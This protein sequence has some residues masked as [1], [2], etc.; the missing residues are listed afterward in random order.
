MNKKCALLPMIPALLGGVTMAVTVFLPYLANSY[1]SYS[2]IQYVEPYQ[3]YMGEAAGTVFIILIAVLDLFSLLTALFGGL[4]K[5]IPVIIFDVLA[6][7]PFLFLRADFGARGFPNSSIGFSVG[8][9]LF[10]VGAVLALG[11]AVWMIVVKAQAKKAAALPVE[12]KAEN[13]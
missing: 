5:P 11:G 3:T 12:E 13:A 1:D 2:L 4:R 9:W 10:Y 6:F 7:A 8:Y